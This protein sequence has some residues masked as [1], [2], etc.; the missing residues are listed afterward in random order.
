MKIEESSAAF[1]MG[2]E[3]PYIIKSFIKNK[4]Q[5]LKDLRLAHKYNKHSPLNVL[6][7]LKLV[8]KNIRNT[9]ALPDLF[10][11]YTLSSYL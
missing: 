1:F 9:Y 10:C 7:T 3:R 5:W 11:S 2:S 8:V 4:I 6:E